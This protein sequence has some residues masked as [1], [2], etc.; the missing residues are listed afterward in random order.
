MNND[1]LTFDQFE[2]ALV[3]LG[4]ISTTLEAA[5]MWDSLFYHG[6]KRYDDEYNLALQWW[7]S[8]KEE[9][10]EESEEEE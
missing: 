2:T 7:K 6:S 1:S 9:E 4:K 8:A 5:D 10:E 3:S